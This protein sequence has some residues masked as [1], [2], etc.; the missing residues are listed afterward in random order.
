MTRK[1]L[2]RTAAMLLA[3][4]PPAFAQNS[5]GLL[6]PGYGVVGGRNLMGFVESTTLQLR[7]I[8]EAPT[9][10]T[11]M[12]AD[13]R[14][15][16]NALYMAR[17][18]A[19]GLPDTGF[20]P[21]QNGRRRLALP[22]FVP[23]AHGISVDGAYIQSD[24]KPVFFGGVTPANGSVGVF[25][26]LVCRLAVAGN[27]D[28]S[29]GSNGCRQVRSFLSTSEICRVT[30]AQ[31]DAIGG[32]VAVGNCI[33]NDL[34]TRPFITR[35]TAAGAIDFEFGAGAG[36]LTPQILQANA[37]GQYYE[38][39]TLRPDGRI[40]VLGH[41]LTN[42]AGIL[43]QDLGVLQF[44]TGG[45]LDSTFSGDG[46]AL[47]RYDL[48]GDNAEFA[49]DIELR[50]D[51][52]LLVLGQTTTVDP[53]RTVAVYAQF[54]DTG[55]LDASFGTGGRT[56]DLFG[57]TLGTASNLRDLAIDGLGRAVVGGVQT[58]ASTTPTSA[59]TSF[60]IAFP[61]AAPPE[62]D[63]RL[64][65]SSAVR[66]TGRVFNASLGISIPF[67]VAPGAVT[68]VTIPESVYLTDSSGVTTSK[69]LS[70]T[71]QA[72]ITVHSFAGRN[73]A[74]DGYLALPTT[75][76]GVNYR[77]MEWGEGLGE[78][79]QLV[80]VG[81]QNN[82]SVTVT[83]TAASAGHP[84]GVPFTIPLQQGQAFKMSAAPGDF[85][86]TTVVANKP[87]AVYGGHSCGLVPN[88]TVDFCEHLVE[89]QVPVERWGTDFF[90]AP[91]AGR[92]TGGVLRVLAHQANTMVMINDTVVAT[93]AAGNFYQTDVTSAVRV[94]SDNAVSVAL[95]AK[96]CKSEPNP[97]CK[98]DPTM[99]TLVSSEHWHSRYNATV[100][101]L[102][103][104]QQADYEHFIEIFAPTT[105]VSDI[106]I[107]GINVPVGAFTP[108]GTSG[109]ARAALPSAPGNHLVT[110]PRSQISVSV[111]GFD[112]SEAYGF[113]AAGA[114]DGELAD[115]DDLILR[116][117][118][119]GARDASFGN[120]GSVVLDHRNATGLSL[121]SLDALQGIVVQPGGGI[122]VG[123]GTTASET[124][125]SFLL[126]YRLIGSTL[127]RDSFE[128]N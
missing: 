115:T 9:G 12:F 96:G 10:R 26:S 25:P 17:V 100:P 59:G 50:T 89:Q 16:V 30:D 88:D 112:T 90:A 45:S 23:Q 108:I 106:R 85:T 48:G 66:T 101:I 73:F 37:E 6:D 116:Y 111:Y 18:L 126:N 123:T 103:L 55:L 81:T 1:A 51:G 70:I 32:V 42:N 107:D 91:F 28:A 117:N 56:V 86:G 92:T 38:A 49:R 20:G 72:P 53:P 39:L 40:A 58:D 2:I 97:A 119:A 124:N 22:S 63:P 77:V 57:S 120:N 33:G 67:S 82:T 95:Y 98:G 65:L 41:F 80:V 104:P 105:V 13:D 15:D 54:T 46:V 125:Q 60:W 71:S 27:L 78:G 93:L 69:G 14:N 75:A 62:S 128:E 3:L 94:N 36:V 121:R 31:E 109:I 79:T 34:P 87:V 84:L 4:T 118:A 52:R 5:D 76:L 110:S 68:T 11:W 43:D 7:A 21:A 99:I 74:F 122:L 114:P 127:F 35:L 44:D 83:P 8:S 24:G 102:T 29:F 64:F 113:P 47:L 19:N 61:R